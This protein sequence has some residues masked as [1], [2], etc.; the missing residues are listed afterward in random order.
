MLHNIPEG[1]AVAIPLYIS[2][3]SEY[4]V[5]KWTFLN[6]LAEPIGVI[7]GGVFLQPYLNAHVLSACLAAVGGVMMCVCIVELLP[8]SYE[9]A[10]KTRASAW[11]F[12]GMLL[13]WLALE[14]VDILF[15]GHGHSH[16]HGP[17]EH[18]HHAFQQVHEHVHAGYEAHAHAHLGDF[19]H[20]HAGHHHE[21]HDHA[22]HHHHEHSHAHEHH[23]HALP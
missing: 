11:F 10:G 9:Y 6:G 21:H 15:D 23:N 13:C 20:A 2:T 1:M 22:H 14:G 7:I 8:T 18:S 17:G 12:V 16:S 5:L 4:Q 3:K 19:K